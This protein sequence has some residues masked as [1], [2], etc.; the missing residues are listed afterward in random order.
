MKKILALLLVCAG[1]TATAAPQ[2]NRANVVK[3]AKANTSM[4]LKSNSLASQFMA[5][6]T[7][8]SGMTIQKFVRDNQVNLNENRLSKKA[9]LRLSEDEILLP[10][11]MF[12]EVYNWYYDDSENLVVE[13][14]LPS[15]AGGWSLNLTAGDEDGVY[16]CDGLYYTVPQDFVVDIA[17]KTVTMPTFIQVGSFSM[18]GSGR[19]RVDT[20]ENIYI[21]NEKWFTEDAEAADIEGQIL[22]DGSFIFEDGFAY[23]FEDILKTYTN[24]RLTATDTA[25]VLSAI[26]RN[27]YMMVPTGT[28]SYNFVSNSTGQEVAGNNAVYMFQQNDTT[29]RVWNLWGFGGVGNVMNIYED[30]TMN[31]PLQ[32]ITDDDMSDYAAQYPNYEFS[33]NFFNFNGGSESITDDSDTPGFV[34]GNKITWYSTTVSNYFTYNGNYYFPAVYYPTMYNNVLTLDNDVFYYE[35]SVAPVITY[36]VTDDAV[37]ITAVGEGT[38]LLATED[39]TIVD[40]P[41]TVE[42]TDADQTIV[43]L[44]LAQQDGKLASEVVAMEIVVPAKADDFLRGDVNNDGAVNISDVTAL[45]DYI[46]SHDATG[47]NLNAADCNL[48]GGINISDVTALIDYILS[49]AW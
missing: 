27:P 42:R 36:E 30:G 2:I 18:P 49:H 17:N 29:V 19:N 15:F 24:N 39:G 8:K 35:K 23:L 34:N 26:F 3:A 6:A 7:G 45:I 22:D 41:Y 20:V 32:V 1:L 16:T 28:H 4:V 46:L 31:F 38:V 43:M 21:V 47:V 40:N 12:M 14:S 11:L 10:K 33:T 13:P 48:D 25:M 9:P 37:I 5:P 44:A